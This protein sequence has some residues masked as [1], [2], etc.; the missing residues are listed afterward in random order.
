MDLILVSERG[1]KC[2]LSSFFVHAAAVLDVK[3]AKIAEIKF[4]AIELKKSLYLLKHK[5]MRVMGPFLVIP[6]KEQKISID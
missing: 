5:K 4:L 2:N 6:I 1:L 3:D